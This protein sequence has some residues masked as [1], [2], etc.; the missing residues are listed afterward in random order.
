MTDIIDDDPQYRVHKELEDKD[1]VAHTKPFGSQL[2]GE[3]PRHLV[4]FNADISEVPS[5]FQ[6]WMRQNEL[7]IMNARTIAESE[8]HHLIIELQHLSEL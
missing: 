1:K 2:V 4:Q 3:P 6:E 8:D 5:E 7:A